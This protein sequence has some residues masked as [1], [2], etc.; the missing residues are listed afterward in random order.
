[1]SGML[2]VQP[3]KWLANVFQADP[4]IAVD[5]MHVGGAMLDAAH[6]VT[7]E[8]YTVILGAL[9][10]VHALAQGA[11]DDHTKRCIGRAMVVALAEMLTSVGLSA[12][13]LTIGS[14]EAAAKA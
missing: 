5:A 10:A 9:A 4:K 6:P 13:D 12:E 3:P 2:E 14:G 8:A 11:P 1:M 7:T